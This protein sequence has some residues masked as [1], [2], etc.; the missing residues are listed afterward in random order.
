MWWLPTAELFDSVT[1]GMSASCTAAVVASALTR[2]VR[3]VTAGVVIS[4]TAEMVT[5]VSARV[6]A[7]ATACVV[8]SST[9]QVHDK[10]FYPSRQIVSD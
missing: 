9:T 6:F 4:G 1:A 5:S 7:L 2:M 3:S 8:V 10:S